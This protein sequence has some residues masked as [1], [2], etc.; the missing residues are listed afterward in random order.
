MHTSAVAALLGLFAM[1]GAG[2]S[3]ASDPPV[4]PTVSDKPIA[5]TPASTLP[6]ADG[7]AETRWRI[8]MPYPSPL[9][10]AR[11]TGDARFAGRRE[12]ATLEIGC[13][14]DD[15]I[16]TLTIGL[17]VPKA[18]AFDFDAF[19]GPEGI[20]QTHPLLRF[21]DADRSPS[22]H[23]VS[24]WWIHKGGLSMHD[25]TYM[26]GANLPIAEAL[27]AD[28]AQWPTQA[29]RPVEFAVMTMERN[30]DPDRILSMR[31]TLPHDGSALARLIA[32]C[33][34]DADLK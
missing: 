16:S 21:G 1:T 4:A 3:V 9:K 8:E 31:F 7:P 10:V 22:R 11:I 13:L 19:E 17:L 25:A 27:S 32:P 28:V 2:C 34:P 29:G 26:F 12:V 14:S 33:F 15:D 30:N 6:K 20:G 5:T 18:I 23:L 24:G